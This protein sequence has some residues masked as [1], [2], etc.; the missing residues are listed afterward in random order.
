MKSLLDADTA[1]V[2]IVGKSSD[3]QARMV[4]SVTP[5]EN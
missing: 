3:Y 2:T 5:E 1:V 4:L